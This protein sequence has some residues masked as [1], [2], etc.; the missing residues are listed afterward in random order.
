MAEALMN[1]FLGDKYEAF[2]AG[3]NPA[4][5]NPMA[6]AVI[7]ELDIDMSNHFSKHA[8]EFLDKKIDYVV[9]VCDNA[10]E[11]CPFL[12]GAGGYIHKSFYDPGT[13]QGPEDM[14][15]EEFRKVRDQIKEWIIETFSDKG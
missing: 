7:E 12:P 8:N 1:K 15:L 2:S 13:F 9:T 6:K 14:K 4:G 11:T 10:K 3:S 5:V